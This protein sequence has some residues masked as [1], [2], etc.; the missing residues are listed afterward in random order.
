M[1]LHCYYLVPGFGIRKDVYYTLRKC[2]LFL[3]KYSLEDKVSN[4]IKIS[5]HKLSNRT[6]EKSKYALKGIDR[7]FKVNIKFQSYYERE[8]CTVK[9]FVYVSLF[10]GL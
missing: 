8:N 9:S 4:F 10:Q 5:E 1:I 6:F 2:L 7:A 3:T